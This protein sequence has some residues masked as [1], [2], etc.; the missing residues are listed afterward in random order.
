MTSK[1]IEKYPNI[2][3]HFYS[4]DAIDIGER[5]Q[6]GLLDFAVMLEP[7]DT[8]KFSY[9]FLNDNLTKDKCW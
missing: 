6:H 8:T 7:V 4:N 2:Q 5:L 1:L 9:L 3:L